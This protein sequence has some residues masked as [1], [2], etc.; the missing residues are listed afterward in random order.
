[1]RAVAVLD[2]GRAFEG[3]AVLEHGD[4]ARFLGVLEPWASVC[5]LEFLDVG[6]HEVEMGGVVMGEVG[7]SGVEMNGVGMGGVFDVGVVN[8]G[9]FDVG[10]VSEVLSACKVI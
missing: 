4:A 2:E 7:M 6:V 5:L 1:M 8:E 9:M 3:R 10:V